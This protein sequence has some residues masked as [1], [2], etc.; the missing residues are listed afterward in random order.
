MVSPEWLAWCRWQ[1]ARQAQTGACCLQPWCAQVW[2][3][4]PLV[5]WSAGVVALAVADSPPWPDWGCA[6]GWSGRKAWPQCALCWTS[7]VTECSGRSWLTL[8][9]P[10]EVNGVKTLELLSCKCKGLEVGY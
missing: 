4:S 5:E 1:A 8:K 7:A 3:G 2:C 6:K 9:L 10:A